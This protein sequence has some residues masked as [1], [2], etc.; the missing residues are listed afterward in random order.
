MIQLSVA[1]EPKTAQQIIRYIVMTTHM[2]HFVI[3]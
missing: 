3:G 2:L 1:G